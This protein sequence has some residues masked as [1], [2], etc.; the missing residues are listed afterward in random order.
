MPN[1]KEPFRKCLLP[2]NEYHFGRKAPADLV[3]AD[4]TVSKESAIVS[5]GSVKSSNEEERAPSLSV[6]ALK[7]AIRIIP[8][9]SEE[10]WK[11]DRENFIGIT[12]DSDSAK[13]VQNG[14]MI[15]LTKTAPGVK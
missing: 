8:L 14:D 3:L 1:C 13:E 15:I 10:E 11:K 2:G 4:K 7:R 12:I 5:I 9:G 6:H